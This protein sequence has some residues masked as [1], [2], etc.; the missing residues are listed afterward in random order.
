M[1]EAGSKDRQW[2]VSSMIISRRRSIMSGIHRTFPPPDKDTDVSKKKKKK[3][4][5][6]VEVRGS[7]ESGNCPLGEKPSGV[8][9]ELSQCVS[10]QQ[11][12][13][14]SLTR[15]L[16]SPVPDYS[17]QQTPEPVPALHAQHGSTLSAIPPR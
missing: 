17:R 11:T 14:C 10:R 6:Q 13:L 3:D 12:D 5:K 8:H 15:G 1:G 7:D 16:A 2:L 9:G 4:E